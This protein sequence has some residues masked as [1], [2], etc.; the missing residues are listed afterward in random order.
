MTSRYM[1]SYNMRRNCPSARA[2]LPITTLLRL[3]PV[4]HQQLLHEVH[5][6]F[7][8]PRVVSLQHLRA[9]SSEEREMIQ[10]HGVP[11]VLVCDLDEMAAVLEEVVR[12]RGRLPVGEGVDTDDGE[13][14]VEGDE[15]GIEG[16]V[17]FARRR[18][19]AV[20]HSAILEINH[21]PLGFEDASRVQLVELGRRKFVVEY[22]TEGFRIDVLEELGEVYGIIDRTRRIGEGRRCSGNVGRIHH[23]ECERRAQYGSGEVLKNVRTMQNVSEGGSYRL[24]P[25]LALATCCWTR[26]LDTRVAKT[27]RAFVV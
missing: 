24:C 2:S 3:F 4:L 13:V 12:E 26:T 15:E 11:F 18:D 16:L 7:L 6:D 27:D 25:D 22:R 5:I 14:D 19:G 21:M 17:D 1:R 8:P 9:P 10:Q 20:G 23:E